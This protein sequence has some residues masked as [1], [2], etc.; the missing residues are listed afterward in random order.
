[1]HVE[2]LKRKL[3]YT[4]SGSELSNLFSQIRSEI[5]LFLATYQSNELKGHI[6]TAPPRDI[7]QGFTVVSG[8]YPGVF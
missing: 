3:G 7:Q 5:F 2:D 8:A 4:N 1:M 6:R